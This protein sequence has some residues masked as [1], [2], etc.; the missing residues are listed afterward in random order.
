MARRRL[1]CD[2]CHALKEKCISPSNTAA[3]ACER[4]SR[5]GTQCVTSR[6]TNE[7][8][9]PRKPETASTRPQAGAEFVWLPCGQPSRSRNIEPAPTPRPTPK[10]RPTTK[11]KKLVSNRPPS[12]QSR[13]GTTTLSLFLYRPSHPI[14]LFAA[15]STTE[16]PL[17]AYDT[18]LLQD[19]LTNR[20]ML[21]RF[22]LCA[23]FTDAVLSR[24]LMRLRYPFPFLP[25]FPRAFSTEPFSPEPLFTQPCAPAINPPSP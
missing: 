21:A 23:S 22:L 17:T 16:L 1:A 9:R 2:R 10:P 3:S 18:L 11:P 24:M 4:C 14:L 19:Y 13:A 5:L 7:V 15:N 25:L 20:Q 12:P 8:G 6:R